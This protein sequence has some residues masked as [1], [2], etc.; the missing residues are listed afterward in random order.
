MKTLQILI[1]LTSFSLLLLVACKKD[2]NEVKTNTDNYF[3]TL[4]V[5]HQTK[6]YEIYSWPEGKVW[7]FSIMVGTNRIKTYSEVISN[8]PSDIHLITVT[9]IDDLKLVLARF[10]ENENITLIGEGWLQS[11]WGSNYG[12]LQLPSQQYID[13]IT[14]VCT[15]RKLNLLVTD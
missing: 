1:L 15:Q 10:P 13:E 9:G 11:S 3:D 6:G 12:N 4:I 2:T 8:T 5:P 14:Q 7:Y